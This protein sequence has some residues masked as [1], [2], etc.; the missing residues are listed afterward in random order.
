MAQG[1]RLGAAVVFVRDLDR[2]VSFYREV[3]GLDL[4]DNSPP[5]ALLVNDEGAQIV[6]RAMGDAAQRAAGGV[7]VQYVVWTVASQEHLDRCE[8]LLRDRSAYR[9][10]R[11][12]TGVVAVEGTDPDGTPVVIA[13]REDGQG[14][15]RGLPARIYAW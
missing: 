14:P 6:L 2:S 5:A 13:Y 10:T 9:Q 7:G 1:V 8:Q 12:D 11:T 15:L 3:L 4:T